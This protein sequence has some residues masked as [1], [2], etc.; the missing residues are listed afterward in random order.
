[1]AAIFIAGSAIAQTSGVTLTPEDIAKLDASTR[2]Q[3]V[4]I[5]TEKQIA[6]TIQATGKWVGLGKEIGAA[7]NES[8]T[9]I[10][11]TAANFAETDLGRFTMF[12]VAYKIIGKD[13]IRIGFGVVWAIFISLMALYL[14]RNNSSRTVL[15]SRI[16]NKEDKKF[17]KT[18]K[19]IDADTD[20]KNTAIIIFCV[21]LALT[22]LIMFA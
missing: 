15:L 1:M 10:T 3:I 4:A 22:P 11:T 8:L 16:W 9:A 17:D 14:Y 20:Y 18:Y 5:Q 2:S 21:G 19:L 12:L 13:I 7:V 6:G